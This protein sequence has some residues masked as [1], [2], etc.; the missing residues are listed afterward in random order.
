MP[1]PETAGKVKTS[2]PGL[3]ISEAALKATQND[4]LPQAKKRAPTF[5]KEEPENLERYLAELEDIFE[6]NNV[7]PEESKIYMALKYMEYRTRLYHVPDA[8]EAAGSWEAFKKLLRKGVPRDNGER[9]L[10]YIREFTIEC[11]KL[12]AQPVMIS[13]QQAVALFLRALDVSIRNA[14]VP[15]LP[16]ISEDTRPEDPYTLTTVVEAAKSACNNHIATVVSI[17]VTDVPNA[18][19]QVSRVT[20]NE[21][22]ERTRKELS[23]PV[24]I[25]SPKHE[26]LHDELW[27]KLSVNADVQNARMQEVV[28]KIDKNTD[29]LTNLVKFL[30][31]KGGNTNNNS[32][33]VES[34]NNNNNY[35]GNYQNNQSRNNNNTSHSN[36]DHSADHFEKKFLIKGD[37]GYIKLRDGTSPP[38]VY[39]DDP[40]SKAERVAAIAK[41]K[42]ENERA[43]GEPNAYEALQ[44]FMGQMTGMMGKFEQKQKEM[45]ERQE[46]R[47]ARRDDELGVIQKTLEQA[48]MSGN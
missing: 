29:A 37:D 24:V 30:M 43:F 15:Y 33:P 39:D 44:S 18:S 23:G 35:R 28:G 3:E 36:H 1:E 7:E 9:L 14:M 10:K 12:T 20:N 41:E 34:S 17:G 2:I 16:A 47:D 26:P 5:D 38:R 40:E 45:E 46:E 22:V 4:K 27:Q 48:Y 31:D 21:T 32:R 6:A 11:N 13:N 25:Q 19:T 42:E 8:K